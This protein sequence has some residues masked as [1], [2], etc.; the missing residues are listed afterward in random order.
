MKKRNR[1]LWIAIIL[2]VLLAA[3]PFYGKALG[4]MIWGDTGEHII[5]GVVNEKGYEYVVI[6]DTKIYVKGDWNYRGS[7][8]TSQELLE[9]IDIGDELEIKYWNNPKWGPIA[10]EIVFEDGSKAIRE[11]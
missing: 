8:F 4:D 10:E 9:R 11:G 2:G 1:G 7:T 3:F 5:K 6:D